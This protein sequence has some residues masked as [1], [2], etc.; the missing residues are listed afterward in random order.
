MQ[1]PYHTLS[2]GWKSRCS[3][4]KSLLVS[5]DVLLL[6]E[7]S[8]YLVSLQTVRSEFGWLSISVCLPG[9]RSHTLARGAPVFRRIGTNYRHYFPRPRFPGQCCRGDDLHQGSAAEVF[10]RYAYGAPGGREEKYEADE[11]YERGYGQKEG[12]CKSHAVYAAECADRLMQSRSRFNNRFGKAWRR[13][14]RP[15]TTTGK[16]GQRSPCIR[17]L[18]VHAIQN[19]NG[20]V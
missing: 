7:P 6:D 17:S 11:D 1:Q 2:G 13:P 3:L 14:R 12:A 9:Y 5:S 15:V 8:N 16:S 20:Q 10:R 19:A 4:A 18:F